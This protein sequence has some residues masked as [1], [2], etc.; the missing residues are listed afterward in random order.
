MKEENAKI[1]FQIPPSLDPTRDKNDPEFEK[2]MIKIEAER[3]RFERAN[4]VLDKY[5]VPQWILD[6]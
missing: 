4:E 2:L 1:E 3:K 6:L 5:P